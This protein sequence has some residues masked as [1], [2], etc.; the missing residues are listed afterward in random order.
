LAIRF[1]DIF[2]P[3]FTV[4]LLTSVAMCMIFF[5]FVYPI[6]SEVTT[7]SDKYLRQIKKSIGEEES[8]G[9][10]RGRRLLVNKQIRA[11]QPLRIRIGAFFY[12]LR[13]T[14]IKSISAIIY[15]TIRTLLMSKASKA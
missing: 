15:W 10:G 1:H 13:F 4:A 11:S 12:V 9:L 7:R 8:Q 6:A 14:S 5:T 3:P 2:P